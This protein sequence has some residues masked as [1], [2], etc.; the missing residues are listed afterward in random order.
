VVEKKIIIRN[1]SSFIRFMGQ[2]SFKAFY[3]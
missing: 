3:N 2:D 1:I